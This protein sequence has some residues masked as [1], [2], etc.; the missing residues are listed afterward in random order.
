MTP[1]QIQE[2]QSRASCLHDS[3]EVEAALDKMACAITAQLA[4]ENPILLC[5]MH[6]GLITSA[7][8]AT[9]LHFPLQMDY[10]HATRYRGET[11]G[12][13]LQFLAY[14]SE[15]LK[16]RAVLLVDD[17]LDV[18]TSLR[19]IRQYCLE[20]QCKSVHSAVLLDKQHNRK[21]SGVKAD[22][23]GLQVADHYLYGY[24]MD[25]KGYLRNAA[26]IFAI[27]AKDM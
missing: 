17:I 20:Q 5:I 1:T 22:F 13:D 3:V 16:D 9:R 23:V 27:D 25:Y 2:V 14:P 21:V 12:K 26:G 4:D 6:G 11:T 24:G 7:K 10:L 18:G 15:S 8:L 19:L